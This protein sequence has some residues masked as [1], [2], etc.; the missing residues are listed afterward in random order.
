MLQDPTDTFEDVPLDVR[1]H[2][3]KPKPKFPTSWKLTAE[4]KA[5]LARYREAAA[6]KDQQRLLAGQ[7]MDGVKQIEDAW[8]RIPV[9]A[10]EALPEMIMA[11]KG[12]RGQ[13]G[14]KVG[15]RR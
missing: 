4:R 2:T 5:E 3:F 1:H 8:A 14:K 6:A 13:K 10:K 9:A 11:G 12:P 7:L 15:I